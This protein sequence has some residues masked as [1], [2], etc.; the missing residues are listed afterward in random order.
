MSLSFVDSMTRHF[1]T[2]DGRMPRH[3]LA[4]VGSIT[5]YMYVLTCPRELVFRW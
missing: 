3:V 2:F 1:L 5:M 4:F